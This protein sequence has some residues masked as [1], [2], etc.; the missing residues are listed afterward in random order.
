MSGW[1]GRKAQTMR[2]LTLA[3]YGDTCHLCRRPGADTADHL[4][5]RSRGG[6]DDLANLRPAHAGCNYSRGALSIEAWR[7][8]HDATATTTTRAPR[9]W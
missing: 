5:P 4:V 2:A 6:T 1:G 3:T 8:R 9:R 7:E